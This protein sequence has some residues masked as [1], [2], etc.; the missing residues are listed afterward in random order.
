MRSVNKSDIKRARK[1]FNKIK[2][3]V[4]ERPSPYEGM[5]EEEAIE[6]MRRTREKIWEK[7]IAISSGHK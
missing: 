1:H 2:H 5:S 6:T 3:L 4:A 7:K